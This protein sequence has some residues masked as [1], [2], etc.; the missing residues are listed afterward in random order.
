MVYA[1]LMGLAYPFGIPAL[2]ALILYL[3]YPQLKE[4]M[5]L[6]QSMAVLEQQ[7]ADAART[8]TDSNQAIV[9]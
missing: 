4:L 8:E 6:E 7:E 1:G 3:F 5:R 9:Q 2:Y